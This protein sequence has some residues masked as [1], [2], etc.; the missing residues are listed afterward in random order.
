[1]SANTINTR[2][3]YHLNQQTERFLF[4]VIFNMFLKIERI[5]ISVYINSF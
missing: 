5:K 1:M 2:E 4:V 3:C